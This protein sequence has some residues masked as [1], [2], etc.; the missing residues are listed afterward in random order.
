MAKTPPPE[1]NLFLNFKIDDFSKVFTRFESFIKLLKIS[2][3]IV[4]TFK[5]LVT[6]SA[7]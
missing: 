7:E 3:F 6:K 4:E 2:V 5:F 1:K